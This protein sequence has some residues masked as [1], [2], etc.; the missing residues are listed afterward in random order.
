MLQGPAVRA[1]R[2]ENFPYNTSNEPP[3]TK[4]AVRGNAFSE[5]NKEGPTTD[6][7]SLSKPMGGWRPPST[8]DRMSGMQPSSSRGA[9]NSRSEIQPPPEIAGVAPWAMKNAPNPF[10][11]R[12]LR[13]HK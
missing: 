6:M 13:D 9:K 11:W 1:Q 2:S 3:E 10:L 8:R 4:K 7:A 12:I 5:A